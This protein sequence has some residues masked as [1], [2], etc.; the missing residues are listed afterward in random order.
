MSFQ[1]LSVVINDQIATLTITRASKLNALNSETLSEIHQAIDQLNADTNV[2]GIILTGEGNKAFVA[3]ADISQMINMNAQEAQAY[4]KFGQD[5]F[6][7]IENSAK[8]VIALINGFALGGGCE[9]A[10]ACHIRIATENAKMGLPEVSLGVIPGFGGTQRLIQY[11]G[12]AKAIE[13]TI[14][15]NIISAGEA[16]TLGLVSYVFA[17][18]EEATQKSLE[19]L[20][21]SKNN[22]S[23][24]IAHAIKAINAFNPNDA[25]GYQVEHE[26]FGTLVNSEDCKEGMGAFLEKRKPNFK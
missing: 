2:R 3:G 4:S 24:A 7:K 6:S 25:K 16:L 5:A 12:K 15:G 22:S 26:T 14:T 9:L 18:I 11:V 1:N 17:T 21:K 10:M 8:P 13:L 19:I 23:I 20:Q